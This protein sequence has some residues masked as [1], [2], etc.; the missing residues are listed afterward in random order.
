MFRDASH[1]LTCF[2]CFV[3]E[4][5]IMC[6]FPCRY[7][8]IVTIGDSLLRSSKRRL[9]VTVGGRDWIALRINCFGQFGGPGDHNRHGPVTRGVF[10][11]RKPNTR[12]GWAIARSEATGSGRSGRPHQ[13]RLSR[14]NE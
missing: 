9:K 12:C 13:A 3:F 11:V 7:I 8:Y 14:H 1:A 6:I 10:S 2:N 4:L 5:Y